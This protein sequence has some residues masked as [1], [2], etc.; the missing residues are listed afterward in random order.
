MPP[1]CLSVC[2]FR[3]A[4]VAVQSGRHVKALLRLQ[5][6]IDEQSLSLF[7][8]IIRSSL[9]LLGGYEAQELH[10]MFMIAFQDPCTATEW[11]VSAQLCL[12]R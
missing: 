7:Q 1:P 10:G 12:H 3:T 8:S 11:A 9:L 2:A 6:A 4:L 5:G